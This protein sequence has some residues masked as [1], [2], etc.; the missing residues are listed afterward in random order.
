[1]Y[2]VRMALRG[3][4]TFSIPDGQRHLTD[5]MVKP[6]MP[7]KLQCPQCSRS[8][9]DDDSLCPNCGENVSSVVLLEALKKETIGEF[10]VLAELGT[11][12]MASVFLAHEIALNRKV[13]LKVISPA[14]IQGR[15]TI[16]RFKRE[17]QTA[18]SLSHPHII[19]IYAVKEGQRLFFFVM[20]CVEGRTLGSII[21]EVGQLPIEMVQAIVSQVGGALGY[22][23][24]R[25]VVHRDIKPDN[26]M[27]DNEGWAVVTDF[28]IAKVSE[29]THLTATGA[30]IG[31]PAYMSPEQCSGEPVT[32][33]S[34]QYSLGVVAYEMLTGK[35][36]FSNPTLMGMMWAHVNT[37]PPPITDARP[38]C[39]K[40]VAE[41]VLQLLAKK[42]KDRFPSVEHA[43]SAIGVPTLAH[44]DPVRTNLIHLAETGESSQLIAKIRTPSS[45]VPFSRSAPSDRKTVPPSRRMSPWAWGAFAVVVVVAGVATWLSAGRLSE[46]TQATAVGAAPTPPTAPTPPAVVSVR[47]DALDGPLI[48]GSAASL[49]AQPLNRDGEVV[50]DA[51]VSWESSDVS[52]ATVSPAGVIAGI[53]A[54]IAQITARS[55]SHSATVVIGVREPAP[56]AASSAAPPAVAAVDVI[57]PRRRLVVGETFGLFA[58][59]VDASGEAVPG[60]T[61][62]WASSDPSIATVSPRGIVTGVSE[63]TAVITATVD[64]RSAESTVLVNRVPVDRIVVSGLAGPLVV[65]ETA[66]LT[67]SLFDGDGHDLRGYPIAWASTDPRVVTVTPEGVLTGVSPG[68][69]QVKISSEGR[70]VSQPVAVQAPVADPP[71]VSAAAV[72]ARIETAI[73]EYAA[74]LAA[75]D[76]ERVKRIY[77]DLPPGRERAWRDIF[78]LGD[79]TVT[80]ENVEILEQSS[81][82]AR[83]RFR[84]TIEGRRLERN[85][86]SFEA[87]LMPSADGWIIVSI[88]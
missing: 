73:R 35:P 66:R 68:T 65:G 36:P 67:V 13:A 4:G 87:E 64:G 5:P 33:A 25:G 76:I 54:G 52:V 41:A 60:R 44:D 26:I 53:A 50:T 86:T 48:V 24:R 69:A 83:T 88:R 22:A 38:D 29:A 46:T 85:T 23:H 63:G 75:R 84:Q 70:S 42:P 18:A 57:P 39:P 56:R 71:I 21:R 51:E 47:I 10:E 17:A 14:L 32:G 15:D 2:A 3:G 82:R 58:A 55:G 11:G 40:D 8:I 31:T 7:T 19:P 79:L 34:D 27:I 61:A 45:P 12:G 74:A 59:P 72:R 62:Q 9:A 1:M 77:P 37:P 43:V 80:V 28:G 6:D 81:E 49:S 30:A 16:E 78:E 20:K